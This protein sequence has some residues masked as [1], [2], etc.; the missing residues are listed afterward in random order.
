MDR[1]QLGN[2][3]ERIAENFLR[4]K[5]YEILG[6]NYSPKFVSGPQRGEV[7]IIAKSNDIISFVEVKTLLLQDSFL[8]E[9]KVD[10]QKQRKIV[11]TAES[12][13]MQNKIPFDSPWQIDIISIKI[14]LNGKKANIRHFKNA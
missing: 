8:P 4:R 13:L 3:G 10:F 12:W 2:L 9:D 14:D 6:K 7:D 5:G 11:K 1:N